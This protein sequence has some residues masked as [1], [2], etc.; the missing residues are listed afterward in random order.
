MIERATTESVLGKRHLAAIVAGNALEF[1]DFL[2]FS[3]FA[4]PIGRTFFPSNRPETSLLLALATFGAGFLTRPLGGIVIGMFANRVGRKPAMLLSFALMGASML[5]LAC[6]PGFATIGILAPVLA[7]VWRLLQGFALGGEVGP[8]TAMLV[9]G[10]PISRRGVYGALQ[11]ATQQASIA[12]VGIVGFWLSG[13]LSA[14]AMDGWGWRAALLGGVMVVPVG[15]V[16]R[17]ALPETLQAASDTAAAPIP[18]GLVRMVVLTFVILASS[19]VGTYVLNTLTT[20][21][22]STLKMD[23]GVGF[24]AT[25]VRGTCGAIFAVLGGALSDRFGRRPPMMITTLLAGVLAVPLLILV[26]ATRAPAALLLTAAVLGALVAIGGTPALTVAVE[27]LPAR[28][29]AGT[30]GATYAFAI[31]VFGGSTPFVV[32]WLTQITHDPLT[33]GWYLTGAAAIG[34]VALWFLP[35]TAP[36][37]DKARGTSTP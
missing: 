11:I 8:T 9:E 26:V 23:P 14:A 10:A 2:I 15:L 25:L 27:A 16:I 29:R 3:F 34:L 21:A 20:Y 6:T 32:T 7:L 22:I 24:A 1:Y 5:G 18:G 19:T 31:S 30:A 35:E 36:A 37:K 12:V 33:P 17:R 28:S 13:H 4:L